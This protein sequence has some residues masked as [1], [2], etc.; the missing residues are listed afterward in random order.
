MQDPP[1]LIAEMIKKWHEG[2]EVVLARRSDRSSD[3]YL[4]R[5]TAKMFYKL[6]NLISNPE[7]PENVGDFR[8]IDR[9][10]I[11]ALKQMK[12]SHR[13]MKGLFAWAGFKTFTLDYKREARSSGTSKFNGLKLWKLAVEGITSFSTAPLTLWLYLGGVSP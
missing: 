1:E 3:S 8:L 6:H 5:T 11:E 2:Y 4:K 7:I 9:K 12:E 10:V 13:F